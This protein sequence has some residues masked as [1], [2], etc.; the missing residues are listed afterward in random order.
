MKDDSISGNPQVKYAQI[1]IA[2]Q[3]SI[4]RLFFFEK[5]FPNK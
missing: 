1:F 3:I 4:Y 2:E 5:N